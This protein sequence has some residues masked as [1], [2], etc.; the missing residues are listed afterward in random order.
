MVLLSARFN[1]DQFGGE[2]VGEVMNNGTASANFVEALATFR[3]SAGPPNMG[4]R[5]QINISRLKTDTDN[6]CN[7]FH[8]LHLRIFIL[9]LDCLLHKTLVFTNPL[10]VCASIINSV[11]INTSR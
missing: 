4:A 5:G 3:D 2:I 1:D 10:C 8:F 6:P 7:L 9:L 11:R